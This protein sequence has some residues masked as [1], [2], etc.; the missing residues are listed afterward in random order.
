[1]H[2]FP[3]LL[4]LEADAIA[5]AR[6]RRQQD[7]NCRMWIARPRA[8]L[9]NN[10]SHSFNLVGQACAQIS[11]TNSTRRGDEEQFLQDIVADWINEF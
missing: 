8:C 3:S 9:R 5:L 2:I 4:W 7:Q 10:G 6:F 1:M 11:S